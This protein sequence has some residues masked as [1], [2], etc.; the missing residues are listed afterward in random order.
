M[1]LYGSCTCNNSVC[2]NVLCYCLCTE[3][4]IVFIYFCFL[5]I[6]NEEEDKKLLFLKRKYEKPGVSALLEVQ[7]NMLLEVLTPVNSHVS[8]LWSEKI[9]L[10]DKNIWKIKKKK[11]FF[12]VSKEHI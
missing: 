12:A 2:L 5:L 3:T 11:M 9:W 8:V 4:C 1:K 10:A 7:N 6:Q